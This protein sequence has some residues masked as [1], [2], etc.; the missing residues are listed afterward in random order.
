MGIPG[1]AHP[2]FGFGAVTIAGGVL[3]FVRKGS[4][5]SLI[6]GVT[7]GSLLIASGMMIS[8]ESQYSGHSLAAGTSAA[9]TLAMGSRLMK[10]GK[11]MPAGE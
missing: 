11:F 10:T 8:G 3:G 5:P 4:R 2:A 7:C 6:A 9:M 1:S